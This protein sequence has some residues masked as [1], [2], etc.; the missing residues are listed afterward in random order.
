MHVEPFQALAAAQRPH[1]VASKPR[2]LI[3]GATGVLGN[4]VLRRLAGPHRFD[5]THVLAR[6]PVTTALR[7]IDLTVVRGEA[8][9]EWPLVPAETGIIMFEP[10]RLFHDR[11]RALWTPHA[12]QVVEVATWMRRCGVTTLVVVMPHDQGRLPEAL[13]RGLANLDEQALATL[14]LG[15]LIIVR[16]A[17]KPAPSPGEGPLGALAR[18]MLSTFRYMLPGSEQPVRAVKVAQFVSAA[19]EL[20]PPGVHIAAPEVVWRAAQ[21]HSR[22]L[23]ATVRQWLAA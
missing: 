19:L 18:F 5:S 11:E 13:K 17:R 4:E 16:T 8:P 2:L 3:A 20:A 22:D 7:G 1:A 15:R 9:G 14:G 6:E 12:D 10:P 21:G 23:H